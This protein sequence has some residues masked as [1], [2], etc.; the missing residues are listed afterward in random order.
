MI[1]LKAKQAYVK[2][3]RVLG[4]VAQRIGL[5]GWLERRQDRR[6]AHWIRALFAIYD[7]DQMIA[8]DVPWWTYRAIDKVDQFLASRPNAS[9]FEFGSG[10]STI[11]LARRAGIVHSTEHDK[12]WYDLMQ[13]RIATYP[14]IRLDCVQPDPSLSENPLYHSQKE[15]YAGQSFESYVHA[16]SRTGQTYDLI[17]ID[18]RAR[19]ACLQVAQSCLA[20]GGMIVFDNTK[21]ARYDQ[22][23]RNSG[24][25]AEH[26][27]GMTPSL[28]YPDKTTL[29]RRALADGRHV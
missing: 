4:V 21:R 6:V 1:K 17:V 11:W 3:I 10:A 12:G 22:A 28:P 8:L 26:F 23:I 15:S 9:V 5:L 18:G 13:S 29:L 19:P 24:L 20:Q 16:I 7:V 25:V 27:G 2:T 14:N